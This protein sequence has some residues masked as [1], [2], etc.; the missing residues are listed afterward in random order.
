[1]KKC[2]FCAEEIQDEAIKCKHCQSDLT[3]SPQQESQILSPPPQPE[4]PKKKKKKIPAGCGCLLILLLIALIGYLIGYVYWQIDD[5]RVGRRA[6]KAQVQKKE[7]QE[8]QPSKT[9]RQ[10]PA[11][12]AK[13]EI[14]PK[15]V[16]PTLKYEI[17]GKKDISY[18][19]TPRMVYR[20]AVKEDGIPP[21]EQLQETAVQIWRDGNKGWKEFTVFMY[22]PKMDTDSAAYGI[23]EFGPTGL[24]S[25]KVN[26][27][28]LDIYK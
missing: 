11:P 13:T 10:P 2:P 19:N 16:I 18:A 28:V 21:K 26:K 27:W 22:L 6:A 3:K 15:K 25:F 14:E 12:K 4:Q 8:K 9:V 17:V 5:W 23:G 24:K 20:V 1:M 7:A